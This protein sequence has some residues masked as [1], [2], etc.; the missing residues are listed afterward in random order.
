MLFLKTSPVG[1]DAMIQ[2]IQQHLH[3]ALLSLWGIA[4]VDYMCYGRAYRNATVKGFI[5]EVYKENNEYGSPLTNDQK[6]LT[7]FFG[8]DARAK[9]D[10]GE[11]ITNVHLVFCMDISKIKNLTHRADEEIHM[12][13]LTILRERAWEYSITSTEQWMDNVLREYSG[14]RAN[15]GMKYL[16]MHPFHCFRVNLEVKYENTNC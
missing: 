10:R 2:T 11:S 15:E 8:A 3:E 14:W 16:D 6:A 5:P 13:I 9:V 7:S 12:D 1:I 4:D